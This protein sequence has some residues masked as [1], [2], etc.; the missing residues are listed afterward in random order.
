MHVSVPHPV[1]M[2]VSVSHHVSARVSVP[3]P[4]STRVSVPHPVSM[5]VS[6]SHPAQV[7]VPVEAADA[8]GEGAEEELRG[9]E[10]A[11]AGEHPACQSQPVL[12]GGGT[13]PGTSSQP[14][15][16][17]FTISPGLWA[18]TRQLHVHV[19]IFQA[20]SALFC[21]AFYCH[22]VHVHVKTE[23]P[24]VGS[25]PIQGSPFFFGKVTALGVLCFFALLFV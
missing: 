12:H 10:P 17:L 25:Y 23:L 22:F 18:R 16:S 19:F 9:S 1:S 24:Q 3:H 8:G 5:R 21:L 15:P 4:P 13:D 6:L 11:S 7:I 14:P 2:C 20:L